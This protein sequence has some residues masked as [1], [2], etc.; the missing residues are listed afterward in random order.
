M[1]N[2]IVFSLSTTILILSSLGNASPIRF[3]KQCFLRDSACLRE[4]SRL[5]LKSFVEGDAEL[6]IE[7]LDKMS[8]GSVEINDNGL[9]FNENNIVVEGTNS[10]INSVSVD[11]IYKALGISFNTS[12]I[13]TGDYTSSGMLYGLPVSGNGRTIAKMNNVIIDLLCFYEIVKNK[14]GYDVMNLKHYD[15]DFNV[16]GGA[17]YFF[18]NAFN[19]DEEKSNQI[20]SIINSHWRIKIYKYGDHFISKIV[21]K[22][23]TGIKNYLASQNLKNI[24]I[25]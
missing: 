2:A 9:I 16:I 10:S 13:I 15:Y 6:G 21:A 24:A 3:Q 5:I 22:I 14:D 17:S 20:H 18:E 25:Y 11:L 7:K 12:L 8:I 1:S 19:D 4:Q 23:F